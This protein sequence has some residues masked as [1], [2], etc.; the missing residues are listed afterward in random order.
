M[1]IDILKAFIYLSN[2]IDLESQML[3]K[4]STIMPLLLITNFLTLKAIA[5]RSYEV[6]DCCTVTDGDK[7]SDVGF[8]LSGAFGR[9]KT[10]YILKNGVTVTLASLDSGAT[11][12]SNEFLLSFEDQSAKKDF[13]I[14]EPSD[15]KYLLVEKFNK[16]LDALIE[17][18]ALPACLKPL[19][20]RHFI[21]KEK[22][23]SE[24]GSE[25]EVATQRNYQSPYTIDE[26]AQILFFPQ[27]HFF[28]GAADIDEKIAFS[29]WMLAKVVLEHPEFELF[30]EGCRELADGNIKEVKKFFKKSSEELAEEF[31][32]NNNID[33]TAEEY[34]K[35]KAKIA[36]KLAP[37]NK[38][39]EI[40]EAFK[41]GIPEFEDL[42]EAQLKFF[43]NPGAA[44]VLFL[45]KKIANVHTAE[46]EERDA[47]F[48]KVVETRA[49]PFNGFVTEMNIR[50]N[51]DLVFGRRNEI[52][53]TLVKSH[54][55]LHPNKKVLLVLGGLHDEIE[56][57]FDGYKF[58]VVNYDLKKAGLD[59]KLTDGVCILQ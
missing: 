3:K 51:K 50:N 48:E 47:I 38:V 14:N 16:L 56:K 27:R 7:D 39:R 23:G 9:G 57:H 19:I 31:L 33:S 22:E 15:N 37:V 45:L 5:E 32:A 29:Q 26:N 42:N 30:L 17:K 40:K 24:E 43:T 41:S 25:K 1:H 35:C 21:S 59:R 49:G 13:P 34:E 54:L 55:S 53:A 11:T 10:R 44:H 52:A 46:T 8:D 6:P 2:S 4:L 36:A 28:L 18:K 12:F 20:A 58:S